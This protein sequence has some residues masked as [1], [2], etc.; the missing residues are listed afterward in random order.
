MALRLYFPRGCGVSNPSYHQCRMWAIT[1]PDGRLD[2][3]RSCLAQEMY[4]PITIALSKKSPDGTIKNIV[5]FLL[6]PVPV[7]KM[8]LDLLGEMILHRW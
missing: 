7:F 2:S 8:A 1:E 4:A 5:V 3:R 6:V